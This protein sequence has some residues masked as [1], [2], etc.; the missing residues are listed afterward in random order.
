MPK[1][2]QN[3]LRFGYPLV[4]SKNTIFDPKTSPRWLPQISDF[5]KKSQKNCS[6]D[7]LWSKMPLGSLQE[8]AKSLPGGSPEPFQDPQR[9]VSEAPERRPSASL[10]SHLKPDACHASHLDHAGSKMPLGCLKEHVGGGA[11]AGVLNTRKYYILLK[12]TQTCS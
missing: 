7:G 8:P 3:Q 1:R 9:A 10:T 5:L 11:A 6:Y 4:T 2:L 12:S